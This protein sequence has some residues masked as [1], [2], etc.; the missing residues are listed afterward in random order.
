M[1]LSVP[2]SCACLEVVLECGAM[3][4]QRSHSSLKVVQACCWRNFLKVTSS[5]EAFQLTIPKSLKF[6]LEE[7]PRVSY[8]FPLLPVGDLDVLYIERNCSLKKNTAVLWFGLLCDA[9]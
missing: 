2:N 7:F 1:A 4:L 8:C 9:L 5:M 3:L 6:L